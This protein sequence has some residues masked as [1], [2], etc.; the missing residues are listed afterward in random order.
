MWLSRLPVFVA[1]V[2]RAAVSVLWGDASWVSI[3]LARYPLRFG[4]LLLNPAL[5]GQPRHLAPA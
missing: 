4:L 3:R 2:A 5:F 1:A